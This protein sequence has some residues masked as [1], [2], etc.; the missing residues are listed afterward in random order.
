MKITVLDGYTLNPGDLN[1]EALQQS[2][3]LTVYDRTPADKTVS[4]S[5]GAEI[6]LTNKTVLGK[7]ELSQ[8]PDLKYIGILATGTNVVDMEKASEQN[9]VVTNIPAYSTPSVAQMTFALLLELCHQVGKHSDSVQKGD[10]SHSKDFCYQLSG[11]IELKDKTMGIVGFGLIGQQIARIAQAFGMNILF[12]NRSKKAIPEDIEAEQVPLKKLFIDA[13]VIS[14]NCPL[15]PETSEMINHKT[16]LSMKKSAFLINTGRGPLI[17]E[18][19]LAEALE[20]DTIAG[21]AADVLS[22]EPPSPTNPLIGAPNC[23][24]TPHIAWKTAEA[25]QRLMDTATLNIK[26]FIDGTPINQVN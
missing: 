16:L 8:L 3:D 11:L 6:L 4:R 25:R 22:T 7:E 1:W 18:K 24:I 14:L 20:S 9:I 26:A 5:K 21:F 2:G 15:T 19:D 17:N 10:W 23:I 13:D 12:S